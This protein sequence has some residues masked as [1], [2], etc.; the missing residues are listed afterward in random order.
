M[1]QLFFTSLSAVTR[2]VLPCVCQPDIDL[3]ESGLL[4]VPIL[5]ALYLQPPPSSILLPS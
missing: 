3:V 4:Y 1:E 2:Q 5:M